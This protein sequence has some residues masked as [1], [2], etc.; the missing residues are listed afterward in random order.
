MSV[1]IEWD[2]GEAYGAANWD[3]LAE[4]VKMSTPLTPP[5]T[6]GKWMDNVSYRSQEFYGKKLQ[7]TDAES[8]FRELF[9]VGILTT[10]IE[11]EGK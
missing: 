5:D 3:D 6:I 7:Y 10:L 11:K 9:R 2:N 4:L 1:Y 8:F